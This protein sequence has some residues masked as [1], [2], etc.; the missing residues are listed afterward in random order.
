M[1]GSIKMVMLQN[2]KRGLALTL[3]MVTLLGGCVKDTVVKEIQLWPDTVVKVSLRKIESRGV[4]T[5]VFGE[6][7]VIGLGRRIQSADLNCIGLV[8][9][10]LSSKRLYVD[11]VAH[12]LTDGFLA[13]EG[14]IDIGVYW[15]F[16]GPLK[17]SLLPQMEIVIN[18]NR[19]QRQP[20]VNW[21]K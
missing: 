12:V 8:L 15:L 1:L 18:K 17:E 6:L 3:A 10:H 14:K 20:C 13:R 5:L 19:N 2:V 7:S 16:D 9:N 4:N 11:S 21:I